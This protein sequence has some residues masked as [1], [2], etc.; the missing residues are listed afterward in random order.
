[1]PAF[2]AR[3]LPPDE[4]RVARPALQLV[5]D[6]ADVRERRIESRLSLGQLLG[7]LGYPEEWADNLE[8]AEFAR[9]IIWTSQD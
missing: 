7:L 9:G 1:M 2:P 3:P 6:S 5:P 8:R 4:E